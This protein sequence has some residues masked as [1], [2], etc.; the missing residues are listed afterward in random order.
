M[1]IKYLIILLFLFYILIYIIENNNIINKNYKTN[2]IKKTVSFADEN[3][4]P[5]QTF[6][7]IVN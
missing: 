3:N 1:D 2:T 4:K 5:L 7:K 6:I